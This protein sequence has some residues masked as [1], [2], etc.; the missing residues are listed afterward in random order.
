MICAVALLATACRAGTGESAAPSASPEPTSNATVT[1]LP[2]CDEIEWISAPADRYADSPIYV[3]N[4]QPTE[5]ILAWASGQPGFEE[6]WIDRDHLG[7]ITVAFSADA[8]ARQADLERLF[9]D[10]GVVAVEVEWSLEELLDL[11]QRIGEELGPLFG[12]ST[13]ASVQQGVVGIGVGVLTPERIAAIEDRFGD[14]PI[15]I[16]G[17]DPADA[18]VAGPQP[19]A[20]DGWRLLADNQGVGSAYRTGIAT[21]AAAYRQLWAEVGL[22]GGPPAVDFESEVVIWFGAVYGSSCPDLRLD[23][24]VVDLERA[25]VHAEIVLVDAPS[26]C[27][28][29]ANPH[30]YLVSLERSRLPVGPFAI[31]L[32]A[33]DP[34]SGVPEERTLVD[35]D[36]STP[37]AV[38]GPGDV[39]GDPSLPEPFINEPGAFVEPGY[40][41]PYRLNVHCGIEWL[42]YVNDIAWR[43][44]AAG[45]GGVPPEWQPAMGDGESIDLTIL[46]Q[47]DPE[48]IIEA[49]A[50]GHTVVYRATAED[51]PGC[52]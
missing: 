51:P 33:D 6:L 48:P 8:E 43:T 30:A 18:P 29:D 17:T 49:T 3:A 22:T 44:D 9:P 32:G 40:P 1:G 11:Q 42:G 21:D 52:D 19:P 7:W 26:A 27:T 13:W 50:N 31:Q 28:S 5:E 23:D 4:E 47:T 2:R 41:A 34:P 36:L 20:G 46:M 10:V 12:P 38:A 37:G 45:D 16:E 24:V 39:H 35:V 25:L 14:E 15:C